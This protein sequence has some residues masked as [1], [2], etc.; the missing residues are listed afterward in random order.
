MTAPLE[1]GKT[2]P[3]FTLKNQKGEEVT[4]SKQFKGGP[5]VVYFYP[6][7]GTPGC[8]R[9]NRKFE[10]LH[11]E[12]TAR[13]ATIIGVSSDSV[14]SHDKFSCDLGLSFDI[15]ADVGATVRNLW[16]VPKA[17]LF[18]GRVTYTFDKDG[19]VVDIFEGLLK[20]GEHAEHALAMVKKLVPDET[21]APASS[22]EP[23]K[24]AEPE[25]APKEEKKEEEEKPAEEEKKEEE[26]PA[27]SQ[28]S[29]EE[30]KEETPSEQQKPSDA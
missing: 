8:T 7:D 27:E 28:Q 2:A 19:R 4:F 18:E 29:E 11:K 12:F 10:Q 23:A 20:G 15:L 3:D 1:V 17:F 24:E 25:E 30:K 6:K 26:T 5:V 14:E 21:P 9:E 13:N 16:K 22:S